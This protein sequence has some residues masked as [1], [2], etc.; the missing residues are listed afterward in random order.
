[1]QDLQ[2]S[3]GFKSAEHE[4]LQRPEAHPST[5]TNTHCKLQTLTQLR[6]F[7]ISAGLFHATTKKSA[8]N[9]TKVDAF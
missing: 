8:A 4:E 3:F 2:R 5:C 7:K 6:V 9:K 1:M